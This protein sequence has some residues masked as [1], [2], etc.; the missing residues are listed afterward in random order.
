MSNVSSQPDPESRV[1]AIFTEALSRSASDYRRQ[2]LDQA[3]GNDINLRRRVESLLRAHEE[4]DQFLDR[5]ATGETLDPVAEEPGTIIGRYRLVEELGQGGFGVVYRAEQLEPVKRQVALKIIKLGMDTKEVIARFEAERQALALMD[6]PN[7]AHVYDAGATATGRPYFVMELVEGQP[8]TDYCDQHQLLVSDRLRL[9]LE[10]CQAVEHAHQRGIVHRDL[11]P[12]NV[13]VVEADG[14]PR[15][16]VIDFGIAK[17]MQG[18]LTDRTL[19]TRRE[20]LLGTPV[21]MS[22]EQLNLDADTVD[23]RSDVYSLGVLLY[24]LMAGVPPFESEILRRAAFGEVQRILRE[25]DPPK[26][27]T[28]FEQLGPKTTE[29]AQRRALEPV[30][31]RRRLRGDLDWV[32]MRA[33]E[34]DPARRYPSAAALAADLE[35]HLR[36]Q[37][38][39]AGPPNPIYR[40]RKL[41]RRRQGLLV[42]AAVVLLVIGVAAFYSVRQHQRHAQYLREAEARGLATRQEP[43]RDT[44][45]TPDTRFIAGIANVNAGAALALSP[46]RTMLAYTDFGGPRWDIW[47]HDLRTGELRN[48]TQG[49]EDP[50]KFGECCPQFIWSPDSQWIAYLWFGGPETD[51]CLR[52]VSRD[53]AVI[54][55]LRPYH[56]DDRVPPRGL[57]RRRTGYSL[58]A[59]WGWPRALGAGLGGYGRVSGRGER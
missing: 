30:A 26:P 34:K 11:K 37:P 50:P 43:D 9:F 41:A 20:V 5:S 12:S 25:V 56:P 10:V 1:H 57:D 17:S 15:V 27:S 38:V 33:L 47:A 46:D 21:Y 24:E 14:Q 45:E 40:L 7:I 8:I 58:S 4:A 6:H 36:Q 13:V 3:C 39:S 29:I 19:V 2:Y 18:R 55:V 48:L 54:R 22:P 28:R 31:L 23:A 42:S 16:K 32:A 52:L 51:P 59:Q 35:R 49:E 53:G 44:A